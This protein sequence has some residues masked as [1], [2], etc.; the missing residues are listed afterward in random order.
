MPLPGQSR[1]NSTSGTTRMGAKSPPLSS[2][3]ACRI[4]EV[5]AKAGVVELQFNGL[6]VK[7]GKTVEQLI[8]EGTPP[9]PY[10]PQTSAPA[11]V[12]ALTE[13]Q[14]ET[15]T[16]EAL[17]LDELRTKEEQL[18]RALIENPIEYERLLRDG[19][20]V[21]DVDTADSTDDGDDI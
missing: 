16:K 14:H 3:D 8:A 2:E 20:L 15:Q 4:I 7:F 10:M 12:T 11:P 18:A 17:E 19:E 6:H 5:S 21:D 1:K 9:Y 13:E